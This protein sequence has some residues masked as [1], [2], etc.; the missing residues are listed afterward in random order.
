MFLLLS[1]NTAA[2]E[3][4]VDDAP[5]SIQATSD[6]LIGEPRGAEGVD[7]RQQRATERQERAPRAERTARVPLAP[8]TAPDGGSASHRQSAGDVTH[9]LRVHDRRLL[10]FATPPPGLR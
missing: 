5:P 3:P 1:P 8:P 7:L 6:E 2:A 10:H 9:C 4:G